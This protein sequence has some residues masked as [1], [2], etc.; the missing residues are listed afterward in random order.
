MGMN[1]A[2][3][4]AVAVSKRPAIVLGLARFPKQ[5]SG[6]SGMHSLQPLNQPTPAELLGAKLF[7]AA[8][9]Y[10]RLRSPAAGATNS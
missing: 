4:A 1:L 3:A 7:P 10:Q 8:C 2:L 6:T 9:R 5:R